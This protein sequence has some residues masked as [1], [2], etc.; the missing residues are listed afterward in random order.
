MIMT[1]QTVSTLL[2]V[3]ST[4]ECGNYNQD[5]TLQSYRKMYSLDHPKPAIHIKYEGEKVVFK[6]C[7]AKTG[8]K[9]SVR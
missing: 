8:E 7:Y 2:L 6:E 4:V 3:L 9:W 5:G 1:R